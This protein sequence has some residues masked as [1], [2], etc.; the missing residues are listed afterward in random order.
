VN[1]IMTKLRCWNETNDTKQGSL[2]LRF[3]K[4]TS[5]DVMFMKRL[6]SAQ[7]SGIVGVYGDETLVP[8][9]VTS[10]GIIKREHKR[11]TTANNS[12]VLGLSI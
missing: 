10:T 8:P 2:V 7:K 11:G 9:R 5:Q 4:A 1:E 12:E 6:A 3:R